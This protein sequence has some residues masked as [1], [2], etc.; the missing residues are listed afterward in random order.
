[1]SYQTTLG[2]LEFFSHRFVWTWITNSCV[3]RVYSLVSSIGKGKKKKDKQEALADDEV[4]R[5]HP[6]H[7]IPPWV[8]ALEHIPTMLTNVGMRIRAKVWEALDLHLVK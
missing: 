8:K 6:F 1:L 2:S 3:F 7:E 5:S 4:N